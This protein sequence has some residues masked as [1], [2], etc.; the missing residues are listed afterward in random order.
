MPVVLGNQAALTQCFSNILGNA[1]KFVARGVKPKVRVWAEMRPKFQT[2]SG[3][4]A[5]SDGPQYPDSN[6]QP[7]SGNAEGRVVRIWFDDN[8]IGIPKEGREKIFG[9]FQRMHGGEYEGTGI[10]LAV[11][12]KVVERMRGRVGVESEIGQGSRFWVELNAAE[13]LSD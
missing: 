3:T 6:T 7:D 2:Q 10:G 13:V 11:V 5:S 12:R 1:V 9:M 4:E 8:G